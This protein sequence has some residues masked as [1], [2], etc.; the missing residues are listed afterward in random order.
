MRCPKC[1]TECA[2]NAVHDGVAMLYGPWGCPG[3]AWSEWAEYDLSTG[4]DPRDERGG[5][6]DQYGGYHPPGSFTVEEG[7]DFAA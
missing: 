6:I 5:M 3:C 7:P 1:N 2:R 4:K